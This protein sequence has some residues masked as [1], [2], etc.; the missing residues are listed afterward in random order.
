VEEEAE[1]ERLEAYGWVS[2]SRPKLGGNIS[3]LRLK[4]GVAR[5]SASK[6]KY[7]NKEWAG[8]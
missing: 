7:D 3:R 1:E 5:S 2:G 8:G 6:G 4:G